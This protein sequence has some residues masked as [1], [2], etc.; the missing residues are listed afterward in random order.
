MHVLANSGI[1]HQDVEA[2]E[3]FQYRIDH[4][5]YLSGLGDVSGVGL[6]IRTQRLDLIDDAAC[7][8]DIRARVHRHFS[9]AR[10]Q[11]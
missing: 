9:T 2:A 10:G 5:L 4:G 7:L 1:E 3:T 6:A 8:L 11:R